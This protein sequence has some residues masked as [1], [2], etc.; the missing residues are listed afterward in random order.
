MNRPIVLLTMGFILSL[1][2]LSTVNGSTAVDQGFFMCALMSNRAGNS[3]DVQINLCGN[4]YNQGSVEFEI[5]Y[6]FVT[7]ATGG[8]NGGPCSHPTASG[9]GANSFLILRFY[10]GYISGL[11][12]IEPDS[13]GNIQHIWVPYNYQSATNCNPYYQFCFT[14][15][16]NNW[17]YCSSS[18]S[19][20][21]FRIAATPITVNVLFSGYYGY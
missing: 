2:L 12:V 16:W 20:V 17:N 4:G 1:M 3:G 18:C 15:N 8:C 11:Q 21:I 6:N 9:I 10:P 7:V 19:A 14:Q 5:R 13:N